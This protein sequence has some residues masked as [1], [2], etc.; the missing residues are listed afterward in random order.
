MSGRKY[1]WANTLDTPTYERLD[2]V[3]VSTDWEQYFPLATVVALSR[4][5]SY[6]T[7][8]LLNT[9]EETLGKQ[10]PQFK[11]ELGWLLQDGFFET[12]SEV[13]TSV[14]KGSTPLQVWQ[15]KIRRRRQF[16]RG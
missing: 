6:H 1:T 12:V 2:R 7:P 13:W 8:L 5:I 15:N 11:F 3:L 9:G 14:K 16:L 10:Q 4:E